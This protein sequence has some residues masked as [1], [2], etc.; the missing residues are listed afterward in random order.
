MEGYRKFWF[1]VPD[2]VPEEHKTKARNKARLIIDKYFKG[3]KFRRNFISNANSG[4]SEIDN[5][6]KFFGSVDDR[7]GR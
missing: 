2:P 1:G 7:N 6:Y 3:G 5:V 4:K